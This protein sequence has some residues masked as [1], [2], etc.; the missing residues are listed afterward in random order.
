VLEMTVE[1]ALDYFHQKE[2][3]RKLQAMFDVGLG[4]LTLGKRSTRCNCV[5]TEK[6]NIVRWSFR[7]IVPFLI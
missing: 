5:V 7:L 6:R 4:F 1:Q 2:V 3:V